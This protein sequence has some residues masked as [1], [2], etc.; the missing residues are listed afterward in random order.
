VRARLLLVAAVL[1][2]AARPAAAHVAPS[3]DADNRYVK[4]TP[5]ADRVRVAYT[6]LVGMQPGRAL[7]PALDTDHDGTVSEAEA[8]AWAAP[9]AE[10]MRG[11]I[12]ITLDGTTVPLA[13]SEVAVGMDDRSAGGGAFSIDLIA[14]LCA[15]VAASRH[16]LVLVDRF[17]LQPAGETEVRIADEPGVRVDVA[18]V[19]SAEMVGHVARFEAVP[20]PFADG[21]R[22]VWDAAR[23][24]PLADGRCPRAGAAKANRA[25]SRWP[26]MLAGVLAASAITLTVVVHRRRTRDR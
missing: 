18:R 5:M 12:A 1:A 9:F 17:S 13:W 21:L 16:E 4:L 6:I 2:V 19:G 10:A 3:E 22:V 7:R 8:D 11:K 15:P 14:W 20:A 24:Q 26:W 23:A 25:T